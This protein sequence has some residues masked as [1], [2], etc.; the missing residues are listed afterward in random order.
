MTQKRLKVILVLIF[1][2]IIAILGIYILSV[3]KRASTKSSII[4]SVIEGTKWPIKDVPLLA[5]EGMKVEDDGDYNCQVTISSGVTYEDLREYLIEL[6]QKGFR[7]YEEYGSL[8]PNRLVVGSGASEINNL[9]W[10]GEKE[11]YVVNVIWAREGVTDDSGLEFPFNFD[12]NLF[13]KPSNSASTNATSQNSKEAIAID[14]GNE[15]S[16][17]IKNGE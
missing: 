4:S 16:G 8:D 17:E 15:E 3:M 14:F 12:M 2:A 13:I 9:V 7:P 1:V 11:N 5:K 10:M 6:Y